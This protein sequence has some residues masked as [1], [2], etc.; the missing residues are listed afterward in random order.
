[1]T[2]S[3]ISEMACPEAG[4]T[5]VSGVASATLRGHAAGRS[6]QHVCSGTAA[7]AASQQQPA[8]RQ[9]AA[10]VMAKVVR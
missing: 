1:M 7:T 4:D 10:K 6:K 8:S 2:R 5:S 9:Q 3:M